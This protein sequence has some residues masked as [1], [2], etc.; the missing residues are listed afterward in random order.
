MTLAH[1]GR[2]FGVGVGPGDPELLTL[3]AARIIGAVDVIAYH[4]ARH[5]RSNARAVVASLLRAEQIDVPLIYPVTAERALPPEGYDAAMLAFY[6]GSAVALAAHLDAGR[7]VAVLCEGDPFFYGSYMYVHDR[8]AARY[9]TEVVPGV[10]SVMAAAVRLG[11][12]LVRRDTEL[13]IVP[14][15]LSEDD[16]CARL[17]GGGAYA[18]MKLGRHFGKVRAALERSGAIDRALYIERA[19]MD[20]E[21]VVPVRDVDPAEVPYFSLV[22]VPGSAALPARDVL[23]AREAAAQPADSK[24]ERRGSV[25]VVGLGPAGDDWRSP[26]VARE[27][28]AASD[29]VGYTTYLSRVP[30]R[31]GQVRHASDN[32]VE[33]HRAQ[34]AFALA[35]AGKRVCVVSAGDPGI[36]AMGAAVFEALESGPPAWREL[37]LR[38]APGISALTAAAARA[39]APLGGDFAVISLSDRLKPW[40]VIE[41]RL[42]AAARADFALALFNPVSSQR[43]HQLDNA[44][45]VLLRHRA[46]D[47]PVV[48]ARDVG[49]P[50]E[51]VRIVT[52]RDLSAEDADMRTLVIVGASTTR[53]IARPDGSSFVY[54]PRFVDAAD[55][56]AVVAPP[57]PAGS[58]RHA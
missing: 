56:R 54:T 30:E 19:T 44:C 26:E 47:T 34:Q 25:V 1:T 3:K 53:T 57:V 41:A 9:V 21:R 2:L 6:D 38:I 32:R 36:F 16:L 51:R 22:I 7:D 10:S 55:A 5:G 48:L 43:R 42:D 11:T 46:P 20:G 8:L 12:P 29:L 15:T 31:T 27:L 23:L 33:V 37:E 18:I 17:S 39:G 40:P 45:G 14:G 58:G 52:L 50:T 24:H 4:A 35:S 13:V 28:A 49:G